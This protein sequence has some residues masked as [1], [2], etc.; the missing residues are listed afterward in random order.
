MGLLVRETE[1][2]QVYFSVNEASPLFLSVRDLVRRTVGA[3]EVL[4]RHLAGL[5][6]VESAVIFGSYAAGTMQPASDVDL[7]VVGSPDRD[8]L[9]DRLERASGE[10]GR[11]VNEA[12]MTADELA[13]RRESGDGFVGSIDAGAVIKVV[14]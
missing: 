8:D 1:G 9:T 11:P 6:G 3:P 7:L 2:R 14:G 5:G 13:R 4:R 12:V 10:I